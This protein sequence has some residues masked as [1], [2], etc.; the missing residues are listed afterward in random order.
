MTIPRRLLPALALLLTA[1]GG[2]SDSA[3]KL[4]VI[5]IGR[6]ETVFLPMKGAW[7]LLPE[8]IAGGVARGLVKFDGNGQI[9]PD[10]ATSWR[11]SDDGRSIIF[12][13]RKAHW[14]DD[15]PVT[16]EDFVRLFRAALAP[17]S[18]HPYKALLTVIENGEAVAAGKKPLGAL[19]VSAPIPEA[20]E[21]RLSAP[22]PNLLQ[23][24]AQPAMGISDRNMSR[25]ALGPFKLAE[26][27][28]R[29]T[30]L[31]NPAF[32]DPGSVQLSRINLR[33][34]SEAAMALKRFKQDQAKVLLGGTTGDFQLARAAAL[35]RFLR[36]DPVR[37]IYGYRPVN[38]N[39]PLGDARVRQALAMVINRE[40]LASSTGAGTASPVYGMVSWSLSELPQPAA[41]A[42]ST[43]PL[44]SRVADARQLMRS[45]RGD[46]GGNPLV[47]KVALPEAPGHA[48]LLKQVAAAWAELGV[49]VQPVAAN[50]D[51]ADLEVLE[52]VA[53]NDSVG[54]FLG[55]YRCRKGGY[56]NHQVDTLLDQARGAQEAASRRQA[57]VAAERLVVIDQPIIPL[58]TPIRWSMVD[59][60]VLGWSDNMIGQ[61]PLAALSL[62]GGQSAGNVR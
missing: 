23:L 14:S 36:L 19:G 41:P 26:G 13:L 9:V 8:L 24:I 31:P 6:Q 7:P 38:M 22:R 34:E 2:S 45:A 29:V 18:R 10:L 61:H 46:L 54:W 42:W 1:C 25:F 21:I 62:I 49:S 32:D 27:D 4:D 48:A 50:A 11:V 12:R 39:G 40:A 28:D 35:D 57:F 55:Q 56:C 5:V 16:G 20:L 15:R 44:A 17:Q 53:P 58:F 52:T 60:D 37:G 33:T 47:L 51:D 30:L 43:I 59:P 3:G